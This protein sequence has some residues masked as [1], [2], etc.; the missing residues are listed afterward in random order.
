MMIVE[1]IFTP[2]ITAAPSNLPPFP[3]EAVVVEDD[4]YHVLSSAPVVAPPDE[5]PLRILDAAHRNRPAPIASVALRD[6]TPLRFLAVIHALDRRP[7][8]RLAWVGTAYENLIREC[9]RLR[10]RSLALPPLGTVHGNL[11]RAI[12]LELLDRSLKGGGSLSLERIWLVD[13]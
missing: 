10:L 9:G 6:G 8:C 3:V 11:S 7:T 1:P 13:S 4:T 5:H 2:S 12:S